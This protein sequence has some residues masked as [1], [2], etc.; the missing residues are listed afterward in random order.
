MISRSNEEV[1]RGMM[2]TLLASLTPLTLPQTP[3][4]FQSGQSFDGAASGLA[5]TRVRR[6][7]KK[8]SIKTIIVVRSHG[9]REYLLGFMGT[10]LH[11]YSTFR[12]VKC[13]LYISKRYQAEFH[14]PAHGP[15]VRKGVQLPATQPQNNLKSTDMHLVKR[16]TPSDAV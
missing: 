5:A 4:T 11:H 7:P 13:P 10:D 1:A 6:T 14:G 2:H 3:P 15:D 9:T 16:D 8:Y 12:V